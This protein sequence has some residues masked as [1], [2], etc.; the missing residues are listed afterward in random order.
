[1]TMSKYTDTGDE[2]DQQTE[3]TRLDAVEQYL[4]YLR[5]ETPYYAWLDPEIETVER[6]FVSVRLPNKERFQ[7]PEVAPE[8]G[9]N[10]GVIMTLVDAVGMA[11]IISQ[12]L[13][14]IGLAT[15]HLNA[16]FHDGVEEPHVVEG[17]VTDVGNTLATADVKVIPASEIDDPDRN[18]I[19]S[20]QATAR[21][22]DEMSNS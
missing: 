12:A 15:T 8:T 21:L 13:E 14:P 2:I 19:A 10:G 9:V 7:P 17:N 6:G 20:A 4:E 16:T 5:E 11:A 22:F 3:Q 1:M 18:I